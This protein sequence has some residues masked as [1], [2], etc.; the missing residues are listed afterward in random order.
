[1]H[2]RSIIAIP[3]DASIAEATKV[4]KENAIGSLLVVSD[5]QSDRLEPIGIFTER[6]LLNKIELVQT[7]G[8]WDKPVRTVM[9]HPLITLPLSRFEEAAQIMSMNRIR[10]LP[11]VSDGKN[12]E[13]IAVISMRDLFER[14]V[15]A[16]KTGVPV[17]TKKVQTTAPKPVRKIIHLGENPIWQDY[18]RTVLKRHPEAG[19]KVTQAWDS[20]AVI[21]VDW[22]GLK[23][24]DRSALLDRIQEEEHPDVFVLCSAFSVPPETQ[25]MMRKLEK[26]PGI[27]IFHK[28]VPTFGFYSALKEAAGF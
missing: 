16:E 22:E 9:S 15:H 24:V 12:P 23:P 17:G 28:P 26:K 10:H 13:L 18:V 11:I 8:F 1:M 6:D 20:S 14:Y 19:F 27:R 4:M 2:R 3:A 25:A 21:V 5:V 7:G